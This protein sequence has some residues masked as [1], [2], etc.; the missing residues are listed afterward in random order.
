MV[1][2]T[3]AAVLM[4]DFRTAYITLTSPT[5]MLVAQVAGAALGVLLTPL[6]FLLFWQTGLVGLPDGPYPNPFADIY[7]GM[8]SCWGGWWWGLLAGVTWSTPLLPHKR[9]TKTTLFPPPH[10]AILGHHRHQGPRRAA[11]QLRLAVARLF[12]RR[13]G[14]VHDSR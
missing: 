8:V 5:A 2:T 7:R 6:A 12:R 4:Q 14:D 1:S 13:H 11:G 3:N 10:N 9:I